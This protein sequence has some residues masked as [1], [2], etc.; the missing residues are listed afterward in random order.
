MMNTTTA[1]QA[2]RATTPTTIKTQAF[3]LSGA[4]G[5]TSASIVNLAVASPLAERMVM[6]C[7]SLSIVG[8]ENKSRQA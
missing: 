7:G 2:P 1:A 4:G 6:V 3:V 8:V 5:T